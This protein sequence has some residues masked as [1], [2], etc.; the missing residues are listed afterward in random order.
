MGRVIDILVHAK[1]DFDGTPYILR[2]LA[3]VWQGWGLGVRVLRGVE[4]WTGGELG[5][6]H[7]DLTRVPPDHLAGASRYASCLNG[8]V[9]DIHKRLVSRAIVT[10][11]DGYTGPVIVK[12]DA[13]YAGAKE[14]EKR[15]TGVR[16]LFARARNRLPWPLRSTLLGKQYPIFPTPADVPWPVWFNRSLVVERFAGDMGPDGLYRLRTWFF[17]GDREISALYLSRHPIAQGD[18]IVDLRIGEPVPEALRRRR[19]ELGFDFGKFDYATPGGEPVLFDVNRTPAA[20]KI[21]KHPE[22]RERLEDLAR[23][24]ERWV[25]GAAG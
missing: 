19:R 12:T 14:Y 23:G 4:R 10:L 21:R 20:G 18:S 6:L 13:N 17:L 25:P 24:I 11:G 16:G 5:L 22:F 8:R 3:E 2:D 7:A 9:V 15:R 1:D